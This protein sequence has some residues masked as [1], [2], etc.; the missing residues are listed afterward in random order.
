AQEFVAASPFDYPA[1]ARLFVAPPQLNPK[2]PGFARLAAPLVEECLDRSRGRAFVLFTSYARLRE[3]YA[4]VRERV[5][6]PIRLQGELPRT[7]LLE[8]FR[9]TPNAVL[10]ATGTFWEGIDVV[11]DQ[12]SCVII[13]RLPFPSPADPLV[14][15]RIESLEGRGYNGFDQYMVPSAIVRLKQGFGRLIRSKSDRGLVALLDGRA[16]SSHYGAT[17]L[18]ALPPAKRLTDLDELTEFF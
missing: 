11:G 3:V 16:A 14:Q 8:W 1:Q 18:N 4:L 6:F 12:L 13:D 17:I 7:H 9:K 2:A 10:F 15:A 5:A